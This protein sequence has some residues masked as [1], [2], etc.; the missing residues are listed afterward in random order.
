MSKKEEKKDNPSITV[1]GTLEWAHLTPGKPNEMSGKYQCDVCQLSDDDVKKLEAAGLEVRDGADKGKPEKGH[2]V[3][4]KA[5]KPLTSGL[6]DSKCNPFDGAERIGNGTRANVAVRPFKYT[7]KGK[8]GIGCGLQ[9]VQITELIEY[10]PAGMFAE[11]EGFV[12]EPVA[13][14]VDDPWGN[15]DVPK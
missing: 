7:Y 14:V 10:A 11:E 15:D 5:G 13:A 2:Y 6:V 12:A 9:A 4:P 1:A 3:T 8:S